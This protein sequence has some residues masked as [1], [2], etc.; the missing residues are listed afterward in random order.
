MR[1]DES[2]D[3]I[4][5]C[6]DIILVFHVF[7]FESTLV[8]IS[9]NNASEKEVMGSQDSQ[10]KIV[11]GDFGYIIE[12]VPHFSDYI[13]NLPTYPNP[14]RSNTAYLD[15]KSVWEIASLKNFI[16]GVSRFQDSS[17]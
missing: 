17:K 10:M 6:S 12:D 13:P 4:C 9:E 3:L 5:C 14:L 16:K 8:H 15:V 2:E 1:V 11:R 7:L